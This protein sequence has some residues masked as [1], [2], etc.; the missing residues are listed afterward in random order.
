VQFKIPKI[1]TL[2]AKQNTPSPHRVLDRPLGSRK[3][4]LP[5]FLDIGHVKGIRLSAVFTLKEITLVLI[6]VID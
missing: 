3:L 6:Y 4:R 2:K 5:E 1:T